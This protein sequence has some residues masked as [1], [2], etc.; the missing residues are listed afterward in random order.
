LAC[1]FRQH[2]VAL[3]AQYPFYLPN[4]PNY[5]LYN[6]QGS[7]CDTLG[8]QPPMVAFWRSLQDSLAGPGAMRFTDIS[9]HEPVAWEWHFGDGASST[10]PSP[11]HNYPASGTYN[12]C[13]SACNAQG[14]CDTLCKDVVV[15]TVSSAVQLPLNDVSVLI[16]PNP[17]VNYLAI[18]CQGK[19]GQL[20]A[21]I[22][23]VNGRTLLNQSF[24]LSAGLL[25][26]DIRGFSSGVY[27]ISLLV[28]G[29]QWNG[30]FVKRE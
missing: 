7:A 18:A 12:V 20:M 16:Y 23:D 21:K 5:R 26:L 10:L 15:K 22:S 24:D 14:I 17:A 11:T 30:K 8:V 4:F 19:Q 27:F 3:P 29:K 9:Y 1:D 25:T 2:D 6:L 13:L 28:E